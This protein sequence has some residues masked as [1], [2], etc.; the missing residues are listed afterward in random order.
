MH[1]V[2]KTIVI[3]DISLAEF[4]VYN[5]VIIIN[6]NPQTV[7]KAPEPRRKE[8]YILFFFRL[9]SQLMGSLLLISTG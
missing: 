3:R 1:R 9:K 2:K 8:I 7:D 6:N 4:F 5:W